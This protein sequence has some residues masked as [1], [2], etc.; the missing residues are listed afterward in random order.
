MAVLGNIARAIRPA[1][2]GLVLAGTPAALPG[3][4]HAQG[5]LEFFLT[6][7]FG[8]QDP[9]ASGDTIIPALE[10]DFGEM[11]G[12]RKVETF[13]VEADILMFPS[14]RFGVGLG[15]EFHVYDKEIRFVDPAG[16]L[17]NG[18]L[19]VKGKAFL[20]TL[21]FYAQTGILLNYIGLGSGI[22]AV[23]YVESGINQNR[24]RGSS[25]DVATARVGTRMEFGRWSV[26]LEYGR[27]NAPVNVEFRA[28][29]P[30]L[31]LGGPFWNFGAG[32]AF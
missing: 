32:Y 24:F 8:Q 27:T 1:M 11:Q 22:Y 10:A 29:T 25:E 30:K 6:A 19:Q 17:P 18:R 28:G 14:R 21:K 13:G 20:Y 7:K 23:K 31:E 4:V 26:V 2:I 12:D 15:L 5:G 16:V 3:Y 9:G